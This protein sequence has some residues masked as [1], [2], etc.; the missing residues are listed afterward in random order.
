MIAYIRGI[1]ASKDPGTAVVEA[2]GIGYEIN[3]PTNSSIYLSRVGE[4]VTVHTYLA[5]RED[6]MSLY[7]F[8][9]R[10]ELKLFKLLITVNGIGAKAAMSIL[11]ALN[12]DQLKQA[13]AFEDADAI[14]QAQG[15]GKKTAQR[16]VLELRDKVEKIYEAPAAAVEAGDPDEKK[17]ALD[18]LIVLGYSRQEAVKALAG[19][20]ADDAEG[21][22][23]EALKKLF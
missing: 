1:L 3:I 5:V 11:S 16:V 18:A 6:D 2:G 20:E 19:T 13:I 9:D 22:I 7:G 10:E 15:V 12:A 8:S 23:K 21:Y 4:E 17:E 14:C